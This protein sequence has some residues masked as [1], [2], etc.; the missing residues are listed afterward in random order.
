[1]GVTEGAEVEACAGKEPGKEGGPV[2]HPFE[3]VLDQRSE[4]AEVAFGQVGQGSLEVRP[5]R[6]DRFATV[7]GS[8][9][10]RVRARRLSAG[11]GC[12]GWPSGPSGCGQ[13]TWKE[14][15]RRG[16]GHLLR[17]AALTRIPETELWTSFP[18]AI[19]N[20]VLGLLSMLLERPTAEG[21]GG[22][23]GADT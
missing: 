7:H 4:L 2:L 1:V 17:M 13:A 18:E 8:L 10:R 15:G 14:A 12:F 6:L 23:H 11:R 19:R 3:P 22:E 9:S 21:T 16:R 5:D 20:E